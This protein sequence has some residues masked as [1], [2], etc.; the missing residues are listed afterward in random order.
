MDE[1]KGINISKKLK[2]TI[3]NSMERRFESFIVNSVISSLVK[4]IKIVNNLKYIFLYKKLYFLNNM[5]PNNII[6]DNKTIYSNLK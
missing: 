2:L 3:K 5:I 6:V 4:T 1:L